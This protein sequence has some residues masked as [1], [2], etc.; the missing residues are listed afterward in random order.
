MYHGG[1]GEGWDSDLDS[2]RCPRDLS[3]FIRMPCPDPVILTHGLRCG[4]LHF[5]ST[6]RVRSHTL[7]SECSVLAAE[8]LVLGNSS[9]TRSHN[10]QS[11]GVTGNTK[12]T[13]YR[14]I[15]S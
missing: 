2:T 9:K 13:P 3:P 14:K 4:H 15:S 8:S 10:F 5:Q 6:V 1:G 11:S 12:G 7:C